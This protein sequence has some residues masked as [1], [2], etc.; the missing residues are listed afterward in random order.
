MPR[1]EEQNL[2][3]PVVSP[4]VIQ[5]PSAGSAGLVVNELANDLAYDDTN[6]P[7]NYGTIESQEEP[8]DTE[9]IEEDN[10]GYA[11]PVNRLVLVCASLYSGAFLGALDT[12]VLTTLLT[13]IASDLNELP[14]SSWIATSYLLSCS[15]FQPLFGKLSDIFGRKPLIIFCNLAFATGCLICGLS[16]SL[17]PIVIGRFITGIGGGGQSTLGTITMSDLVSLRKRGMFQGTA[18]IFFG[19]GSAS[20]GVIGGLISDSLGWRYVFLLQVPFLLIVACLIWR[21][22]YFPPGSAGLGTQEHNVWEKIKQVDFA[23]SFFLVVALTGIM[24]DAALGGNSLPYNGLW[25]WVIAVVSFASLMA[26]GYIELYVAAQPTIPVR[27]LA[28]RTVLS[29]SLLNWF[30]TMGVF[31][32]MYYVPI[33][34]STVLGLTATEN[35]L[36]MLPNFFSIAFGSFGSGIYMKN[37]G[38][39]KT[40]TVI[41][42]SFS[43]FGCIRLLLINENI[44]LW[45]QYTLTVLPGVGYSCV[46]TVTL[47]ALIS[48]VAVEH[49]LSTTSIQYAFRLTGSTIG[50]SIGSAIFQSKLASSVVTKITEA[51]PDDVSPSELAKIIENALHS[52]QYISEAPKWCR[53]IIRFSY[54]DGCVMSFWF[55]LIT[56]TLGYISTLFMKENKLHSTIKRK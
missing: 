42:G 51:C 5:D 37:T 6:K 1:E 16:N 34:L 50:V 18:N 28:E 19:L 12:T 52:S 48:S 32:Y 14:R 9:D 3:A 35:G 53:D 15:A 11:I 7:L 46:L 49:Q 2:L 43:V 13:V 33:W 38:K 47:L 26:F 30:Y 21:N 22:L 56:V 31:S 29:S 20:G 25:F 27:L 36:R 40:L 23:G 44:S 10:D 39:Y 55:S 24:L 41:V 45:T 54:G 4:A 17:W 8:E